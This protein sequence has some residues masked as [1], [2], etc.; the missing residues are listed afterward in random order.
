MRNLLRAVRGGITEEVCTENGTSVKTGNTC[1]VAGEGDT[2]GGAVPALQKRQKSIKAV[3][4]QLE[5][6]LRTKDNASWDSKIEP[7]ADMQCRH[8][9][10]K[11]SGYS[12]SS[13]RSNAVNPSQSTGGRQ[14]WF[15]HT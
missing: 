8:G 7:L 4:R 1:D 6:L 15:R 14:A 2:D 12:K 9:Q 11:E 13:R 3:K 5:A 10:R